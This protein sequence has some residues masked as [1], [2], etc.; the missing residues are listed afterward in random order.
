ML[1][2]DPSLGPQVRDR[3]AQAQAAAGRIRTIVIDMHHLTRVEL[4]EHASPG[5][6]EMIDFGKSAGRTD[7]P[8]P[9]A[10]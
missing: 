4:F 3:I 2:E 1:A 7:P 9:P 10:R 8:P 5:L 6:P